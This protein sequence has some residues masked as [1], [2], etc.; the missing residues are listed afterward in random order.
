MVESPLL[1]NLGLL[2]ENQSEKIKIRKSHALS[3]ILS[4][5]SIPETEGVQQTWVTINKAWKRP[6]SQKRIRRMK[7]RSSERKSGQSTKNLREEKRKN[8]PRKRRKENGGSS[9]GWLFAQPHR[10]IP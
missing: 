4:L 2:G 5:H 1:P 8:K 7:S 3:V 10:P 6:N 9:I